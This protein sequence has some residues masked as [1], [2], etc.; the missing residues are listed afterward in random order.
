MDEEKQ[1]PSVLTKDEPPISVRGAFKIA[2]HEAKET[3]GF[4]WYHLYPPVPKLPDVFRNPNDL[5][6]MAK[7]Y[8]EAKVEMIP[9]F[10]ELRTSRNW[11]ELFARIQYLETRLQHV[12]YRLTVLDNL[13]KDLW[14]YRD[15]WFQIKDDQKFWD[16]SKSTRLGHGSPREDRIYADIDKLM[17]TCMREMARPK[18]CLKLIRDYGESVAFLKVAQRRQNMGSGRPISSTPSIPASSRKSSWGSWIEVMS[19]IEQRGDRDMFERCK[20][21]G[22]NSP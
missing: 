14:N 2:F 4:H 11:F 3:K 22:S 17:I 10:T 7:H 15:I 18:E 13:L 9:K 12:T 6:N 5:L 8:A 21:R 19:G 1:R 20:I 16:L